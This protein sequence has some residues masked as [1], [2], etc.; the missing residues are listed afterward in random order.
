[1]T[2]VASIA[3][4]E[5]VEILDYKLAHIYSAIMLIIS[6]SVLFLVYF[7]NQKIEKK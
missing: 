7:I 5:A 2:K 4:Y 1:K 6:F 3:I